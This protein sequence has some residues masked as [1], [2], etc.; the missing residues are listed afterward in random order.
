[1][2]QTMYE[3]VQQ[4]ATK[5][6]DFKVIYYMGKKFSYRFVIQ[7]IE[8]LSIFMS[9]DL[10]IQKGDVVTICLPN[11]PSAVFLFYA[12]NRLGA[13]ANMVHPFTP[14]LQVEKIM[15]NTNS[16]HIFLFEQSLY[17]E[18][19]SYAKYKKQLTVCLASSYLPSYKRYIYHLQNKKMHQAIKDYHSYDDIK[20]YSQE[21]LP[22]VNRNECAVYLHSG[23]TTGVPKTIMLS[24]EGFN[25]LAQESQN[26]FA[27]GEIYR[28]GMLA[29][30]PTFHGF[31]LCMCVHAPLSNAMTSILVPKFSPSALVKIMNQTPVNCICGVPTLFE[32]LLNDQRFTNHRH[33]KD[34]KVVFCGGDSMPLPLKERFDA[35][36][37][38]INSTCRMMEGYGLT[39]TVTVCAVNTLKIN[40]P[41][42]VGKMINGMEC[43]ILDDNDKEVPLGELGEICVKAPTMML[44]YLNEP[45]ITKEVIRDGYVHTGDLGYMD[46]DQ[47]IYFKQ[48]KKRI[49]KVSGV[50]VYPTEIENIVMQIEEIERCAAIE[51]KDPRLGAAV[52]LFVV[53]KSVDKETLEK[54]I[55]ETCRKNLIK[56]AVPK[57]IEFRDALPLTLIGKVDYL[58]LQKE[59]DEN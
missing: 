31:G 28:N 45:E 14:F 41:G 24:N 51:M 20:N 40:R 2:N 30:L 26:I 58:A 32:S 15:K 42:S 11:I 5:Y 46:Q 34:L 21:L 44:G 35:L 57:K 36:M 10:K 38:S 56:W 29:V 18:E 27:C 25:Y 17:K 3:K 39:E 37:K 6:P 47:F 48:R 50:A 22:P 13:I 49:I 9:H 16:K 33:L 54:K 55:L 4:C 12:V 52:K 43:K 8:R 59:N 53:S 1:M 23:G 19:K 7:E